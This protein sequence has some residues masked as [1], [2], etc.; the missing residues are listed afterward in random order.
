MSLVDKDQMTILRSAAD[1]KATAESAEKDI[2][3]KAVAY[4]INEAANT[5]LTRVIFQGVLLPE[6]KQ[7]L[8]SQGYTLQN[9]GAAHPENRTLIDWKG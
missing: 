4:A 2:Q 5:G 9:V 7:E 3:I 1:S 6:T 8:E